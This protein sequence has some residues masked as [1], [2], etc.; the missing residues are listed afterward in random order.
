MALR[1]FRS[2]DL[3]SLFVDNNAFI[4]KKVSMQLTIRFSFFVGSELGAYLFLSVGAFRSSQ[5]T[6]CQ[7][8][9]EEIVL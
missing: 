8:K 3:F 9:T 6:V 2:I 1:T 4:K 5:Q 7:N